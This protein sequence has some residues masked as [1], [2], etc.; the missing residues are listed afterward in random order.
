MQ[1]S[2]V[3][4]V[5]K[6]IIDDEAPTNVHPDFVDAIHYVQFFATLANLFEKFIDLLIV[7]NYGKFLVFGVKTIL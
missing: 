4:L 6:P 7:I 3:L 1:V 2:L 5:L